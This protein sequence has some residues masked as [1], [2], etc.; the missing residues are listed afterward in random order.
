M[1]S[2]E[3]LFGIAEAIHDAYHRTIIP[4]RNETFIRRATKLERTTAS[5]SH[6]GK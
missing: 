5:I 4:K 3:N 2:P 1:T 6:D